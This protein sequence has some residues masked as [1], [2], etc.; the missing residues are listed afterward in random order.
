MKTSS[1]FVSGITEVLLKEQKFYRP[2]A[3]ILK[4]AKVKKWKEVHAKASKNPVKFWEEAAKELEWYKPWKKAFDGS[5]APFYKWFTGGKCNIVHNCLDRWMGT[6]VE[7][8]TA[9]IWESDNGEHR[10][11]TYKEL[12]KAVCKMANGL[13]SLRVRKGD[14][15][16]IYLQ[17]IPEIAISM[18]A[19]AKIGAEHSVVYAGF[20]AHALKT[21]IQD[22][23]AKVLIT[24]DVGHRRGKTIDM[25]GLCDEAVKGCRSIRHVVVVKQDGVKTPMKKGKDLWYHEL[26][27]KQSEICKTEP[28][29]AEDPAFILYTSGTTGTP[30]GVVH[31]HG[32]Y[33]VGVNRT[34]QWVMDIRPDDVYWC[35]ADPG[36]ITGHSYIVYGPL[37]AGITTV[38]FE[39]VPD[40]PQPDR[41]WKM[42]D[43]Y[44]VTLFYTAPTLVR[45]VMRYGDGWVKKHKLSSI[46]LLGSVGEPIN[47][48]AWRW[49]HKFVGKGRCPIM[50][51]WWQTETGMFMIAPLPSMPLKAGSATLPFPGIQAEVVTLKGKKVPVGKGGYLVIKNQWPAMLRTVFN[52]PKRYI[53]TYWK[54]IPGYYLTGDIAAKDK[55]GYFW[56]QGRSDD[57]IKIAGHRIGPAEIESALVSHKAVVEA[58][59]IGKPHPIKGE[60]AKAFVILKKGH[61]PSEELVGELKKTIRKELGPI[62]VTDEIE[63]VDKLPKTRSGKIMRRVLKAR[64]L[65]QEVGDVTA[66]AD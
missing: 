33:M 50:D 44:K 36:W 24:S 60:I 55:D 38:M 26:V 30:K 6:P 17:N 19:C 29:D 61:L 28:M 49:Y 54:E 35:T 39:G 41:L 23:Q 46:R 37:L 57:V 58:G 10:K 59:V 8:K 66:L 16:A 65:G 43:K 13:K 53:E 14:R 7:K 42:V 32:G 20:S 15:V 40:Y 1:S 51:T 3:K 18:L 5:K 52:N 27:K 21:R 2:S 25:K 34:F 31:V 63:F 9:I 62:A 56:I 4:S 64:E 45:A 47:P 48:E 22:G 11:L 12:N